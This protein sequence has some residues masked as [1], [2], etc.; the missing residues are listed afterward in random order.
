MGLSIWRGKL[1]RSRGVVLL[2]KEGGSGSVEVTMD[3]ASI[4]FGHEGL[5][6]WARG[7]EFFETAKYPT[8]VYRGRLEG[9]A[10]G[11]P[12]SVSGELTLHGIT[13]PVA[14]QLDR[15]KCMPHPIF[16][17]DWCGADALARFDREDFGLVAGKDWGF[18]MNVTLRIQVE[19]VADK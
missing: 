5:N 15:F 11:A 9:F 10:D 13:R 6:R 14:L 7:K 8:A 18:D 12:S 16:K 1:N 4:D 19:A 17:R 3:L 2:D